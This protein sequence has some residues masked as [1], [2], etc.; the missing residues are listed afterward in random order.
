MIISVFCDGGA[1][2]N[3]GP[4][5][6]GVVIKDK[7]GKLIHTIGKRIGFAT[8]NVAEYTSVVEAMNYLAQKSFSINPT[9]VHFFLDSQLVVSQ[10]NGVYKIKNPRL[11]ELLMRI[12]EKEA[13]VKYPIIYTHIP[14]EKNIEADSLVNE[15]LDKSMR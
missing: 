13:L 12:R 11:R 6:V 2:G 9:G 10:L 4:S 5:A 3:P 1:R 8:N 14:R 15:A 7:A